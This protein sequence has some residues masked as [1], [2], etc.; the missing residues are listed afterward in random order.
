MCH[1]KETNTRFCFFLSRNN[2]R[3]S[4]FVSPHSDIV[5]IGMA[6]QLK[7]PNSV[8]VDADVVV[9]VASEKL[10]LVNEL[11]LNDEQLPDL[12]IISRKRV[13]WIK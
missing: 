11:L 5:H 10:K 13:L 12:Q 7:L 4:L 1:H 8:D 3:S 9:G 2:A 6:N